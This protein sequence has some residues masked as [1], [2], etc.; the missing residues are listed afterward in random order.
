MPN[1]IALYPF[2]TT[3]FFKPEN[4]EF[5]SQNL[6]KSLKKEH[7]QRLELD[8]E[9]QEVLGDIPREAVIH[10]FERFPNCIRCKCSIQSASPA[11]PTVKFE[12]PLERRLSTQESRQL[13]ELSSTL[14]VEAVVASTQLYST[15][16]DPLKQRLLYVLG[17]ESLVAAAMPQVLAFVALLKGR[18]VE[19][20]KIESPVLLPS[21]V[22]NEQ[23]NIKN[24]LDI[25]KTEVV[26]P[27]LWSQ[28]S[29]DIFLINEVHSLNL[30]AKEKLEQMVGVARNSILC[31]SIYNISETKLHYL[32]MFRKRELTDIMSRYQ[33]YVKINKS[34]IDF[35]A[36]SIQVIEQT[37]KQLTLELLMTAYE[38]QIIIHDQEGNVVQGRLTAKLRELASQNQ[39]IILQLLPNALNC[40]IVGSPH[41]VSKCIDSFEK[42][43]FKDDVQIRFLVELHPDYKEFISG[44]KNGKMSKIIENAKCAVSLELREDQTNMCIV[45]TSNSFAA[46]KIGVRLLSDELPAEDSFFIPDSYHRPVIG[47]GGS[48]IQTIMRRYNVFIQFSNTYQVPYINIG[49]TRRNNVVIR[50][51]HKN[52]KSIS[53]ARDE[54]M[55]LVSEYSEMQARTFVNLSPG[56]YR[57]CFLQNS[58]FMQDVV[59]D[60]EKKT[61]V[62]IKF[63]TTCPRE[64]V[65]FEVR[66]DE[67]N[68]VNA[69]KELVRRFALEREITVD[70]KIKDVEDFTNKLVVPLKSGFDIETSVKGSTVTLTYSEAK[71]PLMKKARDILRAYLSSKGM[72]VVAEKELDRNSALETRHNPKQEIIAG[73]LY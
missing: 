46:A 66:G 12:T 23:L 38:A 36:G 14:G 62:Y 49:F 28:D 6:W 37:M 40:V 4:S 69:A 32:K 20:T 70:A 16:P 22:G 57:H 60:L 15:F 71:V 29:S 11:E 45:L 53:Q 39:V 63:P 61:G 13:M 17:L 31:S 3:I 41:N 55:R 2:E 68:S 9:Q 25:Y 10:D 48:V 52:Q 1:T 5:T 47:T 54:L 65:I 64:N 24:I 35:V 8:D 34:S 73:P 19:Y 42:E 58:N 59:S 43:E 27:E 44:K 30:L 33:C 21:C 72:Q 26:T 50:C 56:Q 67:Q 7:V 18:F 51:P